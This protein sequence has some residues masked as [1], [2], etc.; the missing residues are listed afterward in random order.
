MA[1]QEPQNHS[2]ARDMQ[3]VEALRRRLADDPRSLAFVSLAEELNRVGE[4]AEA[5]SVA[6]RGLLN[7]PDSV[8]GRLALAVAEAEQDHV[9][10]ALEQIK[11]ALIIDQENPKALALMG[12]ILLK[13]GLAK[14]AV[15]FLS[16]AVKLAPQDRTYG[17]L[18]NEA[19]RQAQN[20]SPSSPPPPV[21]SADSI[22]VENDPWGEDGQPGV[23]HTVFD[24]DAGA[25]PPRKQGHAHEEPTAFQHPLPRKKNQNPAKMGGS[26]AEYSQMM[27]RLQLPED[28]VDSEAEPTVAAAKA[29]LKGKAAAKAKAKANGSSVAPAPMPNG[30]GV[31]PPPSPSGTGMRSVPSK[32]RPPPAAPS[33]IG[34]AASKSQAA[35]KAAVSRA[36]PPAKKT[37]SSPKPE[38]KS[39]GEGAGPKVG[40]A[41]N[42]KIGPA[43]TRMVDEALWVLLGKRSG[44]DAAPEVSAE[45]A[46]AEPNG[47][48]PVRARP[49]LRASEEVLGPR[50][51]RTSER[52]GTWATV[53]TLV[54]L[55]VTGALIGHWVMLSSAGPGP[56]ITS[57]EVKGLATDLERGGLAF[58]LSAEER[59]N[60][61]A[62]SAPQLEPLLNGVRAEVYAR[63][64]RH[65]GRDPDMRS[66]AQEA[67]EALA[68]RRPTVEHLA[69]LVA[70]STSAVQREPLLDALREEALRY[71]E[72]PKIRVLQAQ[73]HAA[74]GRER[75]ALNA[76]FK[77]R[78]LHKQHRAT[79]LELARWYERSDANRAALATYARL[80]D[81]HPLDIE[82]AIERYVLGQSTGSD[83]DEAQAVAQLAG[84]IRDENPEVAKDETGRASLAFAIPLLARG[85]LVEG[86]EALGQAEAAF[87]RS[88]VF[89]RAVAD[90]YLAVGEF[91][92]AEMLYEAAVKL[93]PRK[94]APSV[95]LARAQFAKATGLRVDLTLEA[96]KV[97]ERFEKRR[98]EGAGTRAFALRDS[99]AGSGA[100]RASH[101]Q[102]RPIR[103]S[104]RCLSAS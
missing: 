92:R 35:A 40:P 55:S 30:S 37:P 39:G 34:K 25:V 79:L 21:L 6:Q 19:R 44:A 26:A 101:F 33:T 83:P 87:E 23:E 45:E 49:R 52:F 60:E 104:R 27:Q 29:P 97:A 8:A 10:E 82:A 3:R 22:P 94:R 75:A 76:L 69:G 72:S 31:R 13:R 95:G 99:Q 86:I 2:D 102:A 73:L 12:R 36:A 89:K 38:A 78:A 68:G 54:V 98:D 47:A 85:Q 62:R 46:A 18:L 9:K 41:P 61:L 71:P 4:H 15:Q 77:A 43:A 50:V 1:S 63:R 80:L 14:R 5:A 91:D 59:T 100:L 88:A 11:R 74:G 51:V 56:E 48:E 32:K 57:E 16:H 96:E 53:A 65:F 66:K 70:L 84:L 17:Q 93:A 64:W 7:H 58:L 90:A 67:V 42:K 103:L 28:E 20:A 81:L 24:P